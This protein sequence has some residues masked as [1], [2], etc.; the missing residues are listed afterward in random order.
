MKFNVEDSIY[1]NS[2]TN[3]NVLLNTFPD[4]FFFFKK[5]NTE[6]NLQLS[7]EDAENILTTPILTQC[8]ASFTLKSTYAC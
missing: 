7:Y 5:G 8:S 6:E 1:F 3:Q 2:E 4:F